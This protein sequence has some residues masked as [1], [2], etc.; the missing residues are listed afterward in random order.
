MEYVLGSANFATTE[1]SAYTQ[2]KSADLRE[3]PSTRRRNTKKR[4]GA[5]VG[6]SATSRRNA[7]KKN[8][9]SGRRF[10]LPSD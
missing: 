2:E 4:D 6:M 7:K 9:I 8:K 5:D 10:P 1:K 3:M